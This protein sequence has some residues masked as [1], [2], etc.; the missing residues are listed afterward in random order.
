MKLDLRWVELWSYNVLWR[1]LKQTIVLSISY[2]HNYVRHLRTADY[3]IWNALTRQ[4]HYNSCCDLTA[5]IL[6][7]RDIERTHYRMLWEIVN[8]KKM[9]WKLATMADDVGKASWCGLEAVIVS[10]LFFMLR[11]AKFTVV[12]SRFTFTNRCL[13]S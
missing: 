6:I 9:R 1:V 7:I 3:T 4:D 2:V 13:H 5:V 10:G 11:T 12:D 8:W